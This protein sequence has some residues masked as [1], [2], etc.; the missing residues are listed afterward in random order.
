MAFTICMRYSSL[1]SRGCT[2]SDH[3]S[4]VMSYLLINALHLLHS[5]L[6]LCEPGSSQE[7]H[8][9]DLQISLYMQLA[10]CEIAFCQRSFTLQDDVA[11]RTDCS[12]HVV[13]SHLYSALDC[14]NSVE[15][16]VVGS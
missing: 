8:Y 14:Y 15:S 4:H 10:D 7:R 12:P 5:I 16:C 11:F 2:F 6:L 3:R 9:Q 13:L 1:I